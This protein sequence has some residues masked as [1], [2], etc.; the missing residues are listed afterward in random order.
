MNETALIVTDLS[1]ASEAVAK[2][3][4]NLQQLGISR[5]VLAQ[6]VGALSA[7]SL[8][9][10][11]DSDSAK[12]ALEREK[13]L[14]SGDGLHVETRVMES[15]RTKAIE[16]LAVREDAGLI[17]FGAHS[18]S[19]LHELF[20]GGF[21]RNLTLH[22]HTPLLMLP[23]TESDDADEELCVVPGAC[24]NLLGHL[25]F[26]T[27]F[28]ETADLALYNL[29]ELVKRGDGDRVTLLHVQDSERIEPHLEEKLE[30]FNRIDKGRLESIEKDLGGFSPDLEVETEVAYGRPVSKILELTESK[31]AS[32]IVMGTHGRGLLAEAHL[33]SVSQGV[34]RTSRVPVLLVP[35]RR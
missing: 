28:S 26:P 25:L 12:R 21:L 6:C 24:E 3:G 32:L 5:V 33:G 8:A 4:T 31:A 13:S 16:D 20:A 29:L 11:Y 9:F 1:S 14:L 10:A 17:V 19:L 7:F 30:E 23:L 27:D 2:C 18:Q 34:V 22:A 35:S 15:L